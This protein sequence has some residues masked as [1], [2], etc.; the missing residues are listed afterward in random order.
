MNDEQ[1]LIEKLRRV[2]ALFAGA[3]TPGERN[4][5][6]E[7]RE[8]IRSRL[9]EQQDVDPP[10]EFSFSLQDPWSRRLFTA[11]L[12]RYGIRP[13]RYRRQRQT[14]VMARVPQRFLDETLWPEFSELNKVLNSYLQEVTDRV[15]RDGINSDTSDVE[16]RATQSQL[17][18]AEREV[19]GGR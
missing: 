1:K 6:A 3:A 16:I 15:I 11:L 2:E 12:R 13:F 10:V 14:T 19:S 18:F 4:A 8:R 5:A 7:A 9:A 17:G